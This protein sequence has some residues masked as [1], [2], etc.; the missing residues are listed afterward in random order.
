MSD[1]ARM[2][3]TSGWMRVARLT[4][5]TPART[6]DEI[7]CAAFTD[8]GTPVDP[9]LAER[10][11]QVPAQ[12]LNDAHGP[13]PEDHLV[14]VLGDRSTTIVGRAQEMLGGTCQRL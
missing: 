2:R 10:M 13:L 11:L 3:G 14:Q 1:V 7:V 6:Y 12:V 5:S 4:L 8:N 9:E